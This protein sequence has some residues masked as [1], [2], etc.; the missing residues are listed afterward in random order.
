MAVATVGGTRIATLVVTEYYRHHAESRHVSQTRHNT[1]TRLRFCPGGCAYGLRC[2][3]P[4]FEP[5]RRRRRHSGEQFRS[6]LLKNRCSRGRPFQ[7]LNMYT[8]KNSLYV[9]IFVHPCETIPNIEHNAGFLICIYFCSSVYVI[10][11]PVCVIYSQIFPIGHQNLSK[12]PGMTGQVFSVFVSQPFR[13]KRVSV[14]ISV[15]I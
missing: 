1:S 7:T 11:S 10:C 14:N 13:P 15:N 5:R 6:G 12:I 4:G 3:R 9:F 2:H 8:T